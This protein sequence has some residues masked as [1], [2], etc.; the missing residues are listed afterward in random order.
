LERVEEPKRKTEQAGAAYLLKA[1]TRGLD[2]AEGKHHE[3]TGAQEEGGQEQ[4][5]RGSDKQKPH[6]YADLYAGVYPKRY[7]SAATVPELR[8]SKCVHTW[9]RRE[10]RRVVVDTEYV[11]RLAKQRQELVMYLLDRGGEA[12]EE[13]LLGRFGSR[14]TRPWDFRRR[15][16]APLTGWRYSRDKETGR[17][18]RLEVGPPLVECEGG[19]V[20]LLPEWR[21]ALEEHRR[22]TDEHG[23]NRRQEAKMDDASRAWRERD[24]SLAD[25]QPSPLRGKE[26]MRGILR[27]AKE[28]DHAARIEEQRSKVGMTAEVFLADA[29]QDAS[30]FGW[31][32]LR[33]LWVAKGGDTEGL[34]R[35][36]KRPYRFRRECDGGPLYVER[37]G[38]GDAAELE[39]ETAPVAVLRE[40]SEEAWR[41]HPLDCECTD[42]LAPMPYSYARTWGGKR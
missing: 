31:R 20:R 27:A 19:M 9:G 35:A 15:K 42:C 13:E 8:H 14:T 7:P 16:I 1:C 18:L 21:E 4:S 10:G 40:K 6:T 22:A 39:R 32:E 41:K 23:D 29:L 24:R 34:R 26:E 12:T 3:G 2:S 5:Q 28:R 36:V 11:F 37:V 38:G 17:E 33:A 30:G 25:E